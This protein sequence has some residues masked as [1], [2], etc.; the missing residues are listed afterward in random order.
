MGAEPTFDGQANSR[1]LQQTD[2]GA[3]IYR[4]IQVLLGEAA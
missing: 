1:W 2:I 4:P 3:V